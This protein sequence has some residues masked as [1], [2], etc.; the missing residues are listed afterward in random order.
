MTFDFN[1]FWGLVCMQFIVGLLFGMGLRRDCPSSLKVQLLGFSIKKQTLI[2]T[3][4]AIVGLLTLLAYH[5]RAAFFVLLPLPMLAGVL[6]AV[7]VQL[8]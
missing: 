8:L 2:W 7:R 3:I 4:I 1:V 6:Y 5:L